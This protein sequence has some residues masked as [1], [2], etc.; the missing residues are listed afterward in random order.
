MKDRTEFLPPFNS[1][2]TAGRTLPPIKD[3][4]SSRPSRLPPLFAGSGEQEPE[5]E[6]TIRV[7]RRRPS[8]PA[9]PGPRERAEAPERRRPGWGGGVQPSQQG[10]GPSG[11]SGTLPSGG[12]PTGGLPGGSS[13]LPL[14]IIGALVIL[15]VV[16]VLPALMEDGGQGVEEPT[17]LATPLPTQVPV[18]LRPTATATRAV[19]QTPTA[20]PPVSST[21]P[22]ASSSG[23][24]WLVMLYN[25]A[26]DKILEQD[27]YVD[28]NEAERVGS[29][30]R[31]HIV[32]Q[33][34]RYRGGFMGDGDWMDTR[35]YYITKDNDLGRIASRTVESL[36][37]ANMSDGRTLVDFVTWAMKNYPAQ[38]HVLILSDHGMGWPGGWSDP[39]PRSGADLNVPLAS[40]LGNQLY[41]MELD[42]ALQEV[43]TRTGLDKFELIGL[44][45]C[46]MGH[47]E[48]FSTLAAH[49]RY[50]VASQETEPAVGWAYAKFLKSLA[51]RPD[52]SGADLAK[53][54][55]ESYI[56]DDQRIL[57]DQARAELLRQSSGLS[58][59]FG[60]PPR[61]TAEQL[62][63]QMG[64]NATLTAADL[65]RL[66][67]LI[68]SVNNLA[69]ALR[70]VNQRSVAQAR[71]YAQSFTSVFGQNVP[72]SYIDLGNFALLLKRESGSQSVSQAVD[73]LVADLRQV[74]IAEKHGR[75]K[76]GATGISI[77][78]PNSQL[79][80]SAVAGPSSYNVIARRFAGESLWDEFLAFHYAGRRFEATDTGAAVPQAGQAV[81]G[82]GSGKIEISPIT[83]SSK[84]AAPGRP[85]LMSAQISGANIGYIYLLV[86]F[87]DQTAKS[88]FIADMDYLESP[89]TREIQ[90][91]YYPGWGDKDRFKLE[92]EWEPLMYAI[93]DG[94]T[95]TLAL[96]KPERY[97]ASPEEAIYSVDGIYTYG[98]GGES[99]YAR[100]YFGNGVLLHAFGFTGQDGSGAPREI[101]PE[102]GDQFTVLEQWLD[103]N[104]Q[105]QPATVATQQGKTLTFGKQTLTW[106]E[107]D[108]AAGDYVIGFIVQDL[109]GNSYE[110]HTS[111]TVR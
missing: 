60:A 59:L 84:V 32:A 106:K 110:A 50:A 31:V 87:L 107:L 12:W 52:M 42:D 34:D 10:P 111:V 27:I 63:Q 99:R 43:R 23:Q 6:E 8:G 29:T 36:G 18:V 64:E 55:V 101:V 97:G 104:E 17:V 24:T 109:D 72:P 94:R 56:R 93:S 108:A 90:G 105:G 37:E 61:V 28:L 66:P 11:P 92:F 53:T 15:V 58:G 57:D 51:D 79:Y 102:P 75:G 100:L 54:I 48:V 39:D 19:G 78:F 82:P 89:T 95:S 41:L 30:D 1:T 85:V 74:V 49:A 81:R 70:D 88:I 33:V 20:A 77:Y 67:T 46:L 9:A 35:R 7:L 40:A 4:A 71:T 83:L 103:T 69:V 21:L 2:Q 68:K 44:D 65:S 14:L 16:F 96:L 5:A 3:V 38:K 26:D 86:G 25:D 13:L 76:P 45:A 47:L 80:G 22:P 73:R 98:Q 62:A 91:V